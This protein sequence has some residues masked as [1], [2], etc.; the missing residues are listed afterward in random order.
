M[1]Q[2]IIPILYSNVPSTTSVSPDAQFFVIQNGGRFYRIDKN[3]AVP[4]LGG[5]G[6]SLSFGTTGVEGN[7][8]TASRSNHTHTMPVAPTLSSLGAAP[9]SH[10]HVRSNITD[11][12]HTHSASDISGLPTGVSSA[13][14]TNQQANFGQPA[15]DGVL[16]TFARSDHYH[17][18]PASP[19]T[20]QST[21]WK[22]FLFEG[23]WQ[24]GGGS[25]SGYRVNK[26]GNLE[27]RV[28]INFTTAGAGGATTL[29]RFDEASSFIDSFYSTPITGYQQ[30]T[31][32]TF[33][34]AMANLNATPA[35][36]FV[37]P[38]RNPNFTIYVSGIFFRR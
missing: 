22:N 20:D 2:E 26:I 19:F 30:G 33:T 32:G 6:G 10:T 17:A 28:I 29:L 15:R 38:T 25:G 9:V 24:S 5:V 1:S 35:L 36:S 16:G 13:N 7:A 14:L 34:I 27:I 23:N 37:N 8:V 11:F 21:P 12:A 31:G 18:L 4:T 3:L